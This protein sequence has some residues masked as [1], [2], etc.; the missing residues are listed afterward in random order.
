MLRI[1]PGDSIIFKMHKLLL[2]FTGIS[3]SATRDIHCD[4]E[5]QSQWIVMESPGTTLNSMDG[6]R[7]MLLTYLNISRNSFASTPNTPSSSSLILSGIIEGHI[8]LP[9][10]TCFITYICQLACRD[11]QS[12]II[13]SKSCVNHQKHFHSLTNESRGIITYLLF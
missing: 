4:K 7:L 10:H 2:K 3:K 1:S 8:K 12:D 5:R 13:L 11:L 6:G 9:S